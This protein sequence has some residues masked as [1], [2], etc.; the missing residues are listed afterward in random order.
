MSKTTDLNREF[1]ESE[2][3]QK[4]R[5]RIPSRRF[6]A[7]EDLDGPVLLLVSAAGAAM[8]GSVVAVDGAHLVNSP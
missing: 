4:L 2:A 5:S 7:L 8:S 3:G 6:S 1:L